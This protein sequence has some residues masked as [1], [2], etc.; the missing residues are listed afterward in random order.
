[1]TWHKEAQG[2]RWEEEGKR[3]GRRM[4]R[5]EDVGTG[6]MDR[7]RS[8]RGGG[9]CRAPITVRLVHRCLASNGLSLPW[10]VRVRNVAHTQ[11][12]RL[13]RGP[14][15]VQGHPSWASVAAAGRTDAHWSGAKTRRH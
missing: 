8:R 10:S 6:H 3:E 11:G 7:V 12:G 1:M 13:G 15:V 2:A 5:R 14:W 4:S 9:T